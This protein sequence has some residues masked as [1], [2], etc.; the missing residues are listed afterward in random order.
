MDL[1]KIGK[2]IALKRKGRELTQRQLAERLGVSDKS[3]SKW[4]RG[5]CL[6]DVS[7]YLELCQALGISINEF[8][9]G[10]DIGREEV[11]KRS[12]DNLIRVAADGKRRQ[13][14]LKRIIAVLLIITLVTLPVTAWDLYQANRPQNYIV[15][16]DRESAEMKTALLLSG[17][18]G[19]FLYRFRTS[20]SYGKLTVYMSEYRRGE[21]IGK[22]TAADIGYGSI[23]SPTQGMIAIVPD[24]DDFSVKLIIADDRGKMSTQIPILEDVEDRAWYGRSASQISERT[25]IRYD[26]EQGLAALIYCKNEMRV[27]D[28]RE[29]ET[30]GFGSDSGFAN[31]FVYYFSFCFGRE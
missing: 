10:E 18:D 12:E 30:Y 21:L 1:V 8:L 20:D 2:Y 7:L 28:L 22:T 5:V 24:F 26:E 27:L 16:L 19:A 3:V 14:L 25:D 11:E 6:P 15:P 4:E 9:A 31:D 17:I 23:G 29:F 13:V